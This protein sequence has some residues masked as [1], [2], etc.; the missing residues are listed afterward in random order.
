MICIGCP[1]FNKW[2]NFN[3]RF[4]FKAWFHL[5]VTWFYSLEFMRYV[6]FEFHLCPAH[7]KFP[8][9]LDLRT[10][11]CTNFQQIAVPKH[12]KHV[13]LRHF[14]MN[15][16]TSCPAFPPAICDI[17]CRLQIQ[18]Q[19]SPRAPMS[20]NSNILNL[21]LLL[22]LSPV[23]RFSLSSFRGWNASSFRQM[24]KILP[25][26]EL[27]QWRMSHDGYSSMPYRHE[28]YR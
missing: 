22:S 24:M 4:D 10:P 2:L 15:I 8:L 13:C 12:V 25:L 23:F 17:F 26:I 21:P 11:Y 9:I 19:N 18:T 1:H 6:F 27:P 3:D 28:G 7:A 16:V 20:I 5:P 14:I